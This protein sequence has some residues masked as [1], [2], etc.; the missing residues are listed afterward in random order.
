MA[1]LTAR[2]DS[3]LDYL[4]GDWQQ[5]INTSPVVNALS[6]MFNKPTPDLEGAARRQYGP[7]DALGSI[8]DKEW[9]ERAAAGPS[10]LERNPS[11]ADGVNKL[12]LLANFLGPGVKLPTPGP[13][14]TGIRAYHGSPHDFDKFDMS[15]IGTGEGA[16]AYG[17]GL[18]FAE[19][20]GVARTYRDQLGNYDDVVKW[21]G[22]QPPTPDQQRIINQLS[23]FDVARNRQPDLASVRTDITRAIN[24]ERM[25]EGMPG[26]DAE[27]SAR[28]VADLR[29]QLAALDGMSGLIDLRPPGRMYE[30]NIKADPEQFL[31]WDKPLAEQGPKVRDVIQ[32]MAP[33]DLDYFLQR[34]KNLPGGGEG[35][36]FLY[37]LRSKLQMGTDDA[38]AAIH[39]AGIPGIKYLDRQSRAVGQGSRNYVVL[40]DKLIEILRKYGLL[41]PVAA[42]T[43]AALNQQEPQQ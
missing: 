22:Q 17:R 38:V 9:L 28:R 7:Q 33:S 2:R 3:L 31:D 23:G 30:V 39:D 20:E 19:N 6:R 36:D 12:G 25:S 29:N 15:K 21:K 8:A 14:P 5:A 18:Y 41:P 26:W 1:D 32:K 10:W 4:P 16:Q 34:G 11:A 40:D 27:R 37:A 13:K 24:Q 42:G 35:R 43:A